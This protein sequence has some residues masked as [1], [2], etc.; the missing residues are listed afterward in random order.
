MAHS[1]HLLCIRAL[2]GREGRADYLIIILSVIA[3]I[4][5]IITTIIVIIIVKQ[6]ISD[7]MQHLPDSLFE[8]F[9]FRPFLLPQS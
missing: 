4:V 6:R 5:L 9:L 8:D 1:S 2:S 3:V 7:N